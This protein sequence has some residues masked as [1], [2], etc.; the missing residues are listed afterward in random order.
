MYVVSVLN[1]ESVTCTAAVA[2]SLLLAMLNTDSSTGNDSFSAS[3]SPSK[4]KSKIAG[5]GTSLEAIISLAEIHVQFAIE[6][7][8]PYD[9]G[10]ETCIDYIMDYDVF[11]LDLN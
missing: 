2:P 3:S 8:S 4:W 9:D 10:C 7:I 1:I 6:L 5:L 11:A